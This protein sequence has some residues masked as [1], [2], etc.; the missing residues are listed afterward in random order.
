[1]PAHGY[2]SHNTLLV[3]SIQA[4]A[5]CWQHATCN[6]VPADRHECA[7]G[8][9]NFMFVLPAQTHPALPCTQHAKRSPPHKNLGAPLPRE[10]APT[11]APGTRLNPPLQGL[12]LSVLLDAAI[13]H[14]SPTK[15]RS[16]ARR[17]GC[18]Q[19]GCHWATGPRS[20]AAAAAAATHAHMR[21]L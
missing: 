13:E 3:T 15:P 14:P 10:Q 8:N 19:Q 2:T 12:L 16:A 7:I 9:K 1:M 5:M 20:C 17:R 6:G 21:S 18:C 11:P 4:G